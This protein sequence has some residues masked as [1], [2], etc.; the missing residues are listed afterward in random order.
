M[1]KKELINKHKIFRN[2]LDFKQLSLGK[3]EKKLWVILSNILA[4]FFC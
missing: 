4:N 3:G 2:V 1:K